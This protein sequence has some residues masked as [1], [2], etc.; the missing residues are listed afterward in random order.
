[1]FLYPS[2]Y[3]EVVLTPAI[4]AAAYGSGDAI[5]T[6]NPVAL[7]NVSAQDER[8]AAL[9]KVTVIDNAA[10]NAAIDI[11]LYSK[12]PTAPT[13]NAAFAPTDADS[14]NLI[15]IV[16][17]AAGKAFSANSVQVKV[18]DPPLPFKTPVNSQRQIWA[19]VVSNGT[20]TYAAVNDLTIKFLFEH[21]V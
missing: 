14:A 13:D 11:Y 2:N 8:P 5:G 18:M 9:V 19:V 21:K 20:P 1:M 17:V 15:G 6:T 16:N 12:K 7:S 10:Q 4:V 3:R